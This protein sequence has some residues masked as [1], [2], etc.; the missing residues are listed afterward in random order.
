MPATPMFFRTFLTSSILN[1]FTT[2]TTSFIFGLLPI[3]RACA[4]ITHVRHPGRE[5]CRSEV[6][7]RPARTFSRTSVRFPPGTAGG[8]P[9]RRP[10]AP[11]GPRSVSTNQFLRIG[12]PGVLDCREQF[13]RPLGV[14]MVLTE[15][16]DPLLQEIPTDHLRLIG[17]VEPEQGRGE[18]LEG[19]EGPG[20][21][22]TQGPIPDLED[23]AA[24]IAGLGNE[25]ELGQRRR[26]VRHR[27]DAV[28]GLPR[29]VTGVAIHRLLQEPTGLRQVPEIALRASQPLHG[30]ARQHVIWPEGVGSGSHDVL[31]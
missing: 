16:A 28:L 12:A 13:A 1:G 8:D 21:V 31:E 30:R 10:S 17:L 23:A 9:R 2:A 11:G 18:V 22:G 20:I 29:T 7:P 26:Q 6:L 3:R 19:T 14:G 27:L 25:L 5:W 4:L 24:E 15:Q